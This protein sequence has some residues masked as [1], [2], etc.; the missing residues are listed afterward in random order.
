MDH[1]FALSAVL[2]VSLGSFRRI[3]DKNILTTSAVA[4]TKFRA[5][6]HLCTPSLQAAYYYIDRPSLA[7]FIN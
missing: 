2:L 1:L 5:D 3:V 6:T 4:S 7:S